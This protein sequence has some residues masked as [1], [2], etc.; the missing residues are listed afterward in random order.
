MAELQPPKLLQVLT[1]HQQHNHPSLS[2]SFYC[3]HTE[4]RNLT[5]PPELSHVSC[6]KLVLPP[7]KECLDSTGSIV[8]HPLP[9]LS[10]ISNDRIEV[11]V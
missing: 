9:I 11:Y 10:Q 8:R 1:K 2:F 3:L 4:L 5:A 7:C 6:A